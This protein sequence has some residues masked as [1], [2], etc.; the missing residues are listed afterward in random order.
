MAKVQIAMYDLESEIDTLA[1]GE[2]AYAE[3]TEA[4][5]VGTSS[6]NVQVNVGGSGTTITET[7]SL[8]LPMILQMM[9]G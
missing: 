7:T 8:A 2:I 1:L 5:W 9:G 4:L 3:D 6:G